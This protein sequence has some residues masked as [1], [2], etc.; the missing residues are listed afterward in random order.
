M[1]PSVR[2][3]QRLAAWFGATLLKLFSYT[4][5]IKLEDRAGFYAST[6]SSPFLLCIWHNRI[7][8]SVLA[9]YRLNRTRPLPLS[10]LT[11]AS[12]DGGILAGFVHHFRMGNIRGSSSKRGAA[13]L[14]E[15]R[16]KLQAGCDIA[17]TPDGPRG[18]CYHLA[19]GIVFFAA[20]SAT[21][22]VPVVVK[23]TAFWKFGKRWDAFRL[24]KP[25][26][27]ILISYLEPLP[28]GAVNDPTALQ[29][30]CERVAG[31]MGLE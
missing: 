16:G 9:D 29:A 7:L 13:A 3:S 11:S 1:K 27:Q 4:L 22:I 21:P 20:N 18:P 19:P 23:M 25:F 28:I 12:K 8:G 26:S 5:R 6:R 14:L 17:I 2:L 24:P 31:V 30:E 10:V 15:T